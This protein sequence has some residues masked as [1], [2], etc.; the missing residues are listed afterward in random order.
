MKKKNELKHYSTKETVHNG[1]PLHMGVSHSSSAAD[2]VRAKC[3]RKGY[4]W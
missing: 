4:T 1:P 3:D 2:S